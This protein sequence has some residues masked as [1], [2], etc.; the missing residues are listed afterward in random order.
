MLYRRAEIQQY[1]CDLSLQKLSMLV[2]FIQFHSN[3]CNTTILLPIFIFFTSQCSWIIQP[4]RSKD[5]QHSIE[6]LQNYEISNFE[7]QAKICMSIWRFSQRQSFSINRLFHLLC[8]DENSKRCHYCDSIHH[9]CWAI[10]SSHPDVSLPAILMPTKLGHMYSPRA[11]C[12]F[13]PTGNDCVPYVMKVV[14]QSF[15]ISVITLQTPSQYSSQYS[16]KEIYF[17]EKILFVKISVLNLV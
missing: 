17:M 8:F 12:Y 16:V 7:K 13:H 1:V 2:Y 3:G 9:S 4:S 15:A 5:L 10:I 11:H 6:Q 14:R